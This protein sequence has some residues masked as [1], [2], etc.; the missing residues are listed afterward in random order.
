MMTNTLANAINY[1]NDL[2]TSK[3]FASTQDVLLKNNEKKLSAIYVQDIF[4]VMRPFFIDRETYNSIKQAVELVTR[5]I[6]R[7]TELLVADA[8]LRKELELSA[9]EASV[10][11]VG[12]KI[13]S[14]NV[15]ARYDGFFTNESIQ[16]IECNVGRTSGYGIN[17]ILC[18]VFESMPIMQEFCERYKIEGSQFNNTFFDEMLKAYHNWGGKNLTNIAIIWE[19]GEMTNDFYQ[20]QELEKKGFKIKVVKAKEMEFR[21]GKLVVGDFQ[22]DLVYVHMQWWD[23]FTKLGFKHPFIRAVKEKA[24]CPFY[25]F[26]TMMLSR[27]TF[28]E[29]L[30]N[31][32]YAHFFDKEV[33]QAL[34]KHIPWTRKVTETKTIFQGKTI[35]LLPFIA[36]NRPNLVLKPGFGHGGKGVVVGKD[37]DDVLWSKT[38]KSA[39]TEPY[40]VQEYISPSKE[41]YPRLT[42]DTSLL[43]EAFSVDYDPYVWNLSKAE[44][45][46][47]RLSKTSVINISSGKACFAAGFVIDG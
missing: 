1:Y 12:L 37:A 11:D 19:L 23:W 29:M 46:V 39:L 40:V 7:L 16:F 35:D 9:L 18:E 47:A 6:A 34:A 30:S 20:F 32:K 17:T 14:P 41:T 8:E 44:G 31:E 45:F 3:H 27:K 43:M 38:L 22:I 5:G 21:N 15:L 13:D 24:V 36:D 33:Q 10:L 26:R 2:L 25:W 42:T 4:Q 28:F